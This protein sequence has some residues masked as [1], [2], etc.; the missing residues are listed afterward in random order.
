MGRTMLS[1]S[2][3][4][5]SFDGWGCFPSLLLTWSQTMVEVLKIMGT[6]FKRSHAG[7]ATLSAPN[8]APG[9]CQPTP[10]L[11]I[12]GHSWAS[13]GQSL[14][15]SMFLYLGSWCAQVLFVPSKGLFSQSCVSSKSLFP[16]SCVSSS[17][18]LVGLMATSS[19]R[20]RKSFSI[21]QICFM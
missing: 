5:F 15:G 1:K 13:L 8:R 12:P 4:R 2:L 19:K 10:P 7:T 16:Q 18:S 11:E 14:M 20:A 21:L 9:H 17:S 6:S 3:I